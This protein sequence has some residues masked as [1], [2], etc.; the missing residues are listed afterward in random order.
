VTAPIIDCAGWASSQVV[1]IE[2]YACVLMLH[3]IGS[4]GDTVIMEFVD[5]ASNPSSPC[6]TSGLAGGTIGPLVP[7]LVQ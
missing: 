6:S 5:V 4:P 1:P 2:N 7:V 3:P